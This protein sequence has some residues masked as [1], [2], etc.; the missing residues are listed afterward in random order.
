MA[1]IGFTLRRLTQRDDLMGIVSGYGHSLFISAGPWLLTVGALVGINS[2]LGQTLDQNAHRLFGS[3]LIYN[4][5]V[6]L[7]VTGPVVLVSTRYLADRVFEKRL[8]TAT[9]LL[10]T[11]M[12]LGT[13]PGL[14]IAIPFYVIACDLPIAT[15]AIALSHYAVISGVWIAALFLSALKAYVRV[16]ISFGIGMATAFGAASWLGARYGVDG[17]LGGFTIGLTVTLIVILAT[18]LSEYRFRLQQPFAVLPYVGRYWDMALGGLV[19]NLAV[20]VDKWIIWSGPGHVTIAGALTTSPIYDGAMFLA[21]LTIIPALAVFTVT[22]E[23][24]FFEDYQ[25]F[26]RDLGQH[27]TLNQIKDNQKRLIT[28]IVNGLRTVLV[29]QTVIAV[30]AIFFAPEIIRATSGSSQ[31][32]AVFRF[33]VLG[34]LFHVLMMFCVILLQYFDARRP[35][36][37]VQMT[38]LAT[39]AVATWLSIDLG[40]AYLGYGYFVAALITF[41]V[42]IALVFAVI[43]RLPYLA[44]VRN[45]PSVY[46]A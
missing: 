34:A 38:F 16:T 33:G 44:F 9:G 46:N 17:A 45:N 20:W 3:I 21:Y 6:S 8:E 27:G 7:V 40:F 19:Y 14:V 41:I 18:V 29:L 28:A 32:I 1:G 36:L 26:Y 22:V 39:S 23:T 31:Q 43:A 11:S 15:V 35:A 37:F 24:D 25:R 2:V 10:M 42:S 30:L 13:M 12:V 5:S 4:F